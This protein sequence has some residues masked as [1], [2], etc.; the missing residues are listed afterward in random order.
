VSRASATSHLDAERLL[1][2][3]FTYRT[4]V[5]LDSCERDVCICVAM[6]C[7]LCGWLGDLY[8]GAADHA[9]TMSAIG[10][11]AVLIVAVARGQ[12]RFAARLLQPPCGVSHIDD[13]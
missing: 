4:R 8:R 9:F 10:A 5:P 1:R 6:S 2:A 12:A 7:W 11:Y 3:L 13:Q